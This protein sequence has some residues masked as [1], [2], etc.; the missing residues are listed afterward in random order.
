MSRDAQA[1]LRR[2]MEKYMGN[3]RLILCCTSTSKI[4][5][6]IRS[7]CLLIRV[8]AP[9]VDEISEL[10]VQVGTKEGVTVSA[11]SARNIATTSD[12]NMRKAMLMLEAAAVQGTIADQV[13]VTDWEVLIEQIATSIISEQSGERIMQVRT[14][15]YEL[16]SHCI[17]ADLVMKKLAF[18]L[19]QKI[20]MAL[21]AE[22]I[23]QAAVYE[24]RLRLGNKA[25]YH[26]EA[27]VAKFM[28]LY[29]QHLMNTR[30]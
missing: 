25:I 17:P 11:E 21:C 5:T 9:S 23:E 13:Q 27:F 1:G 10:L 12:R 7:R 15:L 20:P 6:P 2:T 19:I 14:H 29:K 30:G 26:L 24:H 8:P 3:L 16:I 22:I 28:F 18:S 4:I